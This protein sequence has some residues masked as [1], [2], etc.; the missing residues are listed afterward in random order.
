MK[1]EKRLARPGKVAL[2][3]IRVK[4][5][6][7][8]IPRV[9][10]I[11]ALHE[12]AR[13]APAIRMRGH[14]GD[15]PAQPGKLRGEPAVVARRLPDVPSRLDREVFDV[16]FHRNPAQDPAAVFL[17]SEKAGAERLAEDRG[18]SWRRILVNVVPNPAV[19]LLAIE[20][21]LDGRADVALQVFHALE[22]VR[23]VAEPA[24]EKLHVPA[25][26]EMAASIGDG[27]QQGFEPIRQS[28][29]RAG[30]ARDARAGAQRESGFSDDVAFRV[31][32]PRDVPA[33][34]PAREE[35]DPAAGRNSRRDIL[36]FEGVAHAHPRRARGQVLKFD[37]LQRL[38]RR[39]IPVLF[40]DAYDGLSDER[41]LDI[42]AQAPTRLSRGRS[43]SVRKHHSISR[44]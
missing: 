1:N 8:E 9:H 40:F 30:I 22:H 14:I 31:Q 24:D 32:R 16:R 38:D 5:R 6:I 19:R 37:P 28:P 39:R 41:I 18:K 21:E 33:R 4:A 15:G 26:D 11:A 42:A 27:P 2:I 12:A 7:G 13:C 29:I 17:V 43:V 25:A 36:A 44:D 35:D 10:R 3:A 20:K 23:V 34:R